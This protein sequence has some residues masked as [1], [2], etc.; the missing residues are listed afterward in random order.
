MHDEG[1]AASLDHLP[2]KVCQQ[3]VGILV[4]DA[5]A[6]LHRHR[7]AHRVLHG[8]HRGCHQVRLGHE[9]GPKARPLHPVAGAADVEVDLVIARRRPGPRRHRQLLRHRTAQLQGDGVFG[10]MKGEKAISVAM[11]DGATG[12]HLAIEQ[13]PARDQPQEIAAM[14][15]GPIHHGGDGE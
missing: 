5:D 14:P 8:R 9:A 12:H 15:V 13:R 4:V 11:D 10:L 3:L 7:N 1:A 6:G 2:G